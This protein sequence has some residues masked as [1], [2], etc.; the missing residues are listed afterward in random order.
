MSLTQGVLDII[1]SAARRDG[2]K[3]VRAVWLEIGKLATV[4]PQALRFCF[5]VVARGTCAEGARLEIITTSGQAWCLKCSSAIA[6][7]NPAEGCPTCGSY[8]LQVTGG[9][10]MRVKEL[11]VE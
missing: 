6:V 8:Q 1:Q 11:E 10:E 7:D 3:H 9:D 4:E 2:F 5:D